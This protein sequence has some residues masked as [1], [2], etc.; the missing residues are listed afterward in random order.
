MEWNRK[1]RFDRKERK[2]GVEEQEKEENHSIR[3]EK[4]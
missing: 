1:C 4:E 3:K 2:Q